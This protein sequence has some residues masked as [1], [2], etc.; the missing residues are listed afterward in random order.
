MK[1][2][3]D[4]IKKKY[5]VS[6]EIIRSLIS[7]FEKDLF[8]PKTHIVN[9][10]VRN[11]KA[12]FIESGLTRSYILSRGKEITTWFC[13]EGDIT[14]RSLDF[15]KNRTGFE[16]VQ[17]LEE[18]VTYSIPIEALNKLCREN[19]EIANWVRVFNEDLFLLLQDIRIERLTLSAKERYEKLITDFPD[20]CNRVNLGH[21]A[22]YLGLTLPTLSKIRAEY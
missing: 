12:Y 19:I 5:A 22:S 13:K 2:I 7:Y 8:P 6:D 11:R 21:I 16:Y 20:L 14:Y 15:Y 1:N 17:T 9:A 3:I 4:S 10:H 18:T